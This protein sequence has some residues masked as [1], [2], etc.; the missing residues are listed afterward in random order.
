[1]LESDETFVGGKA[2]TAHKNKPI[3]RKHAVHALVERGGEVRAKHVADVTAKT[4]GE[5]LDKQ[6][7]AKSALHTDDSLANLSI[8]KELRRAPHR[9]PHAGRIRHQG[10]P[11]AHADGRELLRHHQARRDGHFHSVSEQHLQRYC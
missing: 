4:L 9:C 1:M 8:G 6:A 11:G 7:D 3:P 10:R 2:K 5:V